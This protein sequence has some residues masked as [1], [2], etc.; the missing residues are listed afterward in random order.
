MDFCGLGSFTLFQTC[1][2]LLVL[3]FVAL[4]VGVWEAL[5]RQCCK[6]IL[7]CPCSV[8]KTEA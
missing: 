5:T 4:G 6:D 8:L 2:L 1:L 3:M 7:S